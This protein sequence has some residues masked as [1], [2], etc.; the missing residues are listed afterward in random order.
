[1]AHDSD[2]LGPQIREGEGVG[3]WWVREKRGNDERLD[4]GASR[5]VWAMQYGVGGTASQPLSQAVVA[6][7]RVTVWGCQR[8][9]AGG[10]T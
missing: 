9:A 5:R 4:G 8:G 2:Q 1:M 6:T 10:R 7:S 3:G